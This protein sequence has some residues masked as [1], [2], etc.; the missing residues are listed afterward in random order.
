[1][2]ALISDG[3]SFVS[4][5]SGMYSP[6]NRARRSAFAER[7]GIRLVG[8]RKPALELAF[9]GVGDT[10]CDG[11]IVRW[12]SSACAASRSASCSSLI[13]LLQNLT[14]F[15]FLFYFLIYIFEIYSFH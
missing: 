1:M 10:D 7:I 5:Y 9:D 4:S 2:S 14:N 8:V 15:N 11:D 12:C 3:L 6:L 13:N